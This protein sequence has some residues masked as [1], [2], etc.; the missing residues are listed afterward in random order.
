MIRLQD[1]LTNMT[2]TLNSIYELTGIDGPYYNK[3]DHYWF[4][5]D[6]NHVTIHTE[7][8]QKLMGRRDKSSTVIND[9]STYCA[10]VDNII[11]FSFISTFG[12]SYTYFFDDNKRQEELE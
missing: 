12:I 3:T 6:N 10:K 4:C 2:D 8:N 1:G 5:D 7:P 9:K 11:L